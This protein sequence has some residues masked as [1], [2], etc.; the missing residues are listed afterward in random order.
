MR[1]GSELSARINAVLRQLRGSKELWQVGELGWCRLMGG[2]ARRPRGAVC[3]QLYQADQVECGRWHRFRA[4]LTS[5]LAHLAPNLAPN[6]QE[7]WTIRQGTPM[8]A[9]VMPFLVRAAASRLPCCVAQP[10]QC[11]C[12]LLA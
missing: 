8:E 11:A 3:S 6:L 7:C 1:Q 9:H 2:W 5:L 10:A 4:L 12:V